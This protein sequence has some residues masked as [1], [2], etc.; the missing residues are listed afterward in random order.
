MKKIVIILFSC[1]LI[2]I[3]AER[4]RPRRQSVEQALIGPGLRHDSG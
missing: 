1:I 4:L 3:C 2:V